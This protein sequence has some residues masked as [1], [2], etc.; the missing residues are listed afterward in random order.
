MKKT[1]GRKSRDRV[2]L[3]DHSIT[4]SLLT[5][6]TRFFFLKSEGPLN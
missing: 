2:P 4:K 6:K 3:T 5:L 1:E